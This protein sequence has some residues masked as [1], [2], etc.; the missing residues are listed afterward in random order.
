MNRIQ[1]PENSLLVALTLMALTASGIAP[2][3]RLTWGMETLP[4][5]LGLP[6]LLATRRR[7]PLTPLVYRLLFVHGLILMLGGHYTYA[8][9]PVGLWVQDAF[10]LARNHYDRLGHL[11]QGFIPAMLTREILLRQT[12]LK[13]GG[14]LFF[15]TTCVVLAFSACYEFTEWGAAL[16]MGGDADAFLATQGDVWDTQW[17]MLLALIGGLVSQGVLSRLHNK[18]IKQLSGS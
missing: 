6:L 17:D 16:L 14:W 13:S 1:Y 8:R 2:Y 7:F 3:D 5:M 10:D 9:V 11:A 18:Q 4:V 15:L 12:P